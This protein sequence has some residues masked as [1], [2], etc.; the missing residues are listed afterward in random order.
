MLPK[1]ADDKQK[2]G[3]SMVGL[4]IDTAAQTRE[5]GYLLCKLPLRSTHNEGFKSGHFAGKST[6]TPSQRLAI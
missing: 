5:L 2:R 6:S 4:S 3:G 1:Y